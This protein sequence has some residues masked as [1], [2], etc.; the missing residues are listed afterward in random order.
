MLTQLWTS[1]TE[2]SLRARNCQLLNLKKNMINTRVDLHLGS[3]YRDQTGKLVDLK[4][5]IFL[6]STSYVYLKK[7]V[8]V[9]WTAVNP[10][11]K[12]F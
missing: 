8:R 2:S 3:H 7:R 9:N 11:G 10:E 4:P 1:C 6:M 12:R 5:S